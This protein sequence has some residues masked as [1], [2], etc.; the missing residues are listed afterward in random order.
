MNQSLTKLVKYIRL[1]ADRGYDDRAIVGGL[2]KML[3]PWQAEAQE[4]GVSDTFI[5]LVVSRL[6]D[7][8]HLS[9]NSRRETLQGII[10]RMR[11]E[12]PEG[13]TLEDLPLLESENQ[14][15]PPGVSIP[16]S[17][18]TEPTDEALKSM[19]DA[20]PKSEEVTTPREVTKDTS[21]PPQ[22]AVEARDEEPIL[23]EE[24]VEEESLDALQASLTTIQGIGPKSAKTLSKLGLETL[25]DLLW[26]LPRRYDDYSQLETINRLWYG[27]EVTVIGA[28]EAV[29][30]RVVRSGKMKIVEAIISDGT[31]SLRVSWFNQP[32]VAKQL[33]PGKA[34]VLSGK[35]D[36]YLGRLTMNNPDWE[37]IDR[38]QLH[39]NRIV[40]VYPLTSGVTNKWLRRVIHSVVSRYAPRLPDTL[41]SYLRTSADL[42]PLKTAVQQIHFPDDWDNLHA[43]QHRLAFDEMF[44]LQLGVLKQKTAWEELKTEPLLVEDEFT[45]AFVS[46]LPYELTDA[47]KQAFAAIRENLSTETPM[48]RLLQGDVGS[49]KTVIATAAIAVTAQ[50][51]SQSAFMAPTSILAEQHYQTLSKMLPN[52]GSEEPKIRLLIGATPEAEKDEIRTGLEDG[53]ISVVIGTHALLEDPVIFENLGL[54]IIDEQHRFGVEQRA[55]L[56]AKGHNPNLLVMTATPIPRSLA[57]T[58]YGDLDLTVLDES[59]PGRQPIETRVLQPRER[60]RAH[61]FVSSQLDQGRQAFFIFPLVEGSEKVQTKAAVEEHQNLEEGFFSNYKVGLLHG[62]MK[63]DEKE[64]VMNRFRGKEL[65]ILVSTSV[66]EVGVDIPNASV[67]LIEGANHFGLAQLHQFRGRVGRGE[68]QSYCL[69]IPDSD[70][71]TDNERLKA[72]EATNDGFKLAEMDLDQRGPGDFLGTRQS[73]FAELKA[74]RLTD[75]K[76]IELARREATSLFQRDPDLAQPEHAALAQELDRFWTIEKGEMS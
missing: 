46:A 4:E 58:V 68:Y 27:Q 49:G 51:G 5:E 6:R 74:A 43:A 29:E 73:G 55:S 7:Y 3:D 70:S 26:Y 63:P 54:V 67:M 57:L 71:D 61:S 28:V 35:V 50:A 31:G 23:E 12:L 21:P 76:L 37:R 48:N 62:R 18:G 25:G 60:T 53:S 41:P 42:I 32:W 44:L 19:D 66:V 65:D 1:E 34:V 14:I 17:H 75:V 24:E 15:D 10:V 13:E 36:Q 33:K 56:R 2:H 52:H 30:M 64:E 47:Q 59:P 8:G 69:L 38:Q 22:E 39:T 11:E 20:P 9:P 72:M 45:H 16:D 40:P